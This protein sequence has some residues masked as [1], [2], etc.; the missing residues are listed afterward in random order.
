MIAPTSG[1]AR[2]HVKIQEKP[3]HVKT[4]K[5]AEVPEVKLPQARAK[6]KRKVRVHVCCVLLGGILSVMV[7]Y[8]TTGI[9]AHLAFFL[10]TG[11]S[12]VM[13]FFDRLNDR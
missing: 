10:P 4:H 2:A 3:I 8:I 9:L 1:Q 11:P 6:I 13:E 7:T 5:V 12:I